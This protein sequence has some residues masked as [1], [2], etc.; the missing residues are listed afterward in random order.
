MDKKNFRYKFGIVPLIIFPL[1]ALTIIPTVVYNFL[2]VFQ[3]GEL[4]SFNPT[5]DIV[6]IVIG[7][8]VLGIGFYTFFCSKYT[9]TEKT[10]TVNI[11]FFKTQVSIGDIKQIIFY[12]ETNF[13]LF[14]YLSLK[15]NDLVFSRACIKESKLQEFVDCLTELSPSI[16]LQLDDLSLPENKQD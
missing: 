6:L 5:G 1:L 12:R 2:K 13:V 9:I 11:G 16:N 15:A 4:F 14:F 7:L 8:V 10:L 3:V